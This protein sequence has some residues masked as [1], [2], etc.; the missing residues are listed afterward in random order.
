MQVI[1]NLLQF[2]RVKQWHKNLLILVPAFFNGD[3][4]NTSILYNGSLCLLVFC[5]TSSLIYVIND[6]CD[7]ANDRGHA[8]KKTRPLAAG[9]ISITTAWALVLLLLTGASGLLWL[10]DLWYSF[11]IVVLIYLVINLAYSLGAKNIPLVELVIVASGFIL[12]LLGGSF[13]IG[14][15]LTPWIIMCVGSAALLI[16]TAKRR[17]DIA[18]D[19]NAQSRRKV[20]QHYNLNFLDAQITMLSGVTIVAYLL[21]CFSD[22]G[23]QRFGQWITLTAIM[24]ILGI[25]R[26]NQLIIVANQGDDPSGL[27]IKDTMMRYIVTI[28]AAIFFIIIYANKVL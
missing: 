19:N 9:I 26:F 13:V 14:V 4:F 16:V 1:S 20:L 10:S 8:K 17:A 27:L 21:F 7:I 5:L 3:L 18:Q 11:G 25:Q 6:I 22:Y 2:I 24:A 12:R 23:Q 28:W 15:A